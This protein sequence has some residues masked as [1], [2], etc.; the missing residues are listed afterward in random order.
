[1]RPGSRGAVAMAGPGTMPENHGVPCH[2]IHSSTH[3]RRPFRRRQGH[4]Q[5]HRRHSAWA[6]I[7]WIPARCTARSGVAASWADLDTV[8]RRGAGALHLRH[9]RSRFVETPGGEPAGAGQRHRRHR[10]AAPGDHRRRGLGHCRH[11]GGPGR[12]WRSASAL[13]GRRRGW[14]PTAATWARSSSRTP[15]TRCS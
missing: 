9:R 13:S 2:D 1:M 6:G 3:H 8:R 4:R 5:P 14:S 11:P 7:T 10:R 15:R 12:R